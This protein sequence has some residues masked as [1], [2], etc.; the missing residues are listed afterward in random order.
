MHLPRATPKSYMTAFVGKVG[1]LPSYSLLEPGARLVRPARR[2]RQG[3]QV[4]PGYA[5]AGA[6]S[7]LGWRS[8]GGR[9]SISHCSVNAAAPITI[10]APQ[11]AL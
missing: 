1:A 8:R 6:G 5:G 7:P 2:V 10:S 11:A 3:S 9:S 4:T